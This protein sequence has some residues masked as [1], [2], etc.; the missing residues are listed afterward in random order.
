MAL[1]TGLNLIGVYVTDLKQAMHFYIDLLGFSDA[2]E[3][4][5]GRLLQSDEVTL[6]LE[7]GRK[8]PR[9]VAADVAE[10]TAC[11]KS[12]SVKTAFEQL[13]RQQLSFT[14]KYTEF[15]SDFCM[16]IVRDPDGN[17][18]EFAGKP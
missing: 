16:F 17:N 12:H 1:V 7:P 5:P 3:M 14:M 15:S 2:G 4:G 8:Q 13:Q 6:Y 18:I 10:I 9:A 11:F